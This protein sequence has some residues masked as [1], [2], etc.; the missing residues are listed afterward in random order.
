M[1]VSAAFSQL[2]HSVTLKEYRKVTKNIF[3]LKAALRKSNDE[4][5]KSDLRTDM[6]EN[7]QIAKDLKKNI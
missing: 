7:E 1:D 6:F 5:E 4:E 3:S 2:S